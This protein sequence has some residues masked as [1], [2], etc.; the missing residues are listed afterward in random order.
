MPT[1]KPEDPT[2]LHWSFTYDGPVEPVDDRNC[3][4]CNAAAMQKCPKD[5]ASHGSDPSAC[6]TCYAVRIGHCPNH[7]GVV[8]QLEEHFAEHHGI[9]HHTTELDH[10][11]TFD[12]AKAA[13]LSYL[14][15]MPKDVKT[16][17]VQ[18]AADQDQP[19][20]PF[21]TLRLFVTVRR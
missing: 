7:C 8:R 20:A 4:L 2:P 12:I 13:V 21:A 17:L 9:G 5:A 1:A 19:D 3:Q 15:G 10:A 16:I 6:S 11:K 14:D 18:A